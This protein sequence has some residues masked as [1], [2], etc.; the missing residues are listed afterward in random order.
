MSH[1]LSRAAIADLRAIDVYT[2]R[3]FG[4]E[5]AS[6]VAARFRQVFRILSE[7]P[8]SCRQLHEFSGA[9]RPLRGKTVLGVFVVLYEVAPDGVHIARVIHGARHLPRELEQDPGPKD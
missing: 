3:R 7:R 4:P 8:R 2:E 6:R 1:T 5:Q 9:D